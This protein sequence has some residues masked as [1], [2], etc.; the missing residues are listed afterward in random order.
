MDSSPF[1]RH[2]GISASILGLSLAA[3]AGQSGGYHKI[4][5]YVLGGEGGWDYLISGPGEKL[6][7]SRGTHVIVVDENSG[8]VVGDI[9][10]TTGVHGIAFS[11]KHHQG[12]TSNGRD[13]TVT[14]FDLSTYKVIK[15]IPVTGQNPD[16]IIYDP[17]VD[18]VITCNGR[19]GDVS[20]IDPALGKETGKVA[21]GGKLE[22]AVSDSRGNVFVN[23]ETKSEIAEI[24][25]RSLT[26]LKHWSISPGEGPSGLAIDVKT[27]RLFSVTDGKMVVSDA[28]AG[29]MIT[30]FTIGDG[31][32]AAAFDAARH[33][34]FSSNGE[35]G[36]LSVIRENSPSSFSLVETVPTRK[37]AR[38]MALDPTTH[39]IFLVT[40]DL[41]PPAGGQGRPTAKPGS[42]TLLVYGR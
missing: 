12:Y 34:V 11:V 22:F 36:T 18:R 41:I 29:R 42:F 28:V 7:I 32:D 35:T 25:P 3:F 39:K 24:D 37:G 13:N 33:L 16:C 10:E 19:S 27:N 20:V 38:T 26:V 30:A 23:N 31:P 21:V 8:Q 40:A 4:A 1:L 5:S 9:P 6:F 15:K 2:I 14:E 17:V